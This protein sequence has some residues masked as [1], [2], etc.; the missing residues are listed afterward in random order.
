MAT[1][2]TGAREQIHRLEDQLDPRRARA[3]VIAELNE[4]FA[5]GRVPD[6]VPDGLLRGRALSS[7]ISPF[8]DAAG[9]RLAALYMPWLGK[10]FDAAAGAGINLLAAS[11][12]KPMKMMW[13]SYEPTQVYADRVEAFPFTIRVDNGAVDPDARVLKIDYDSSANPRFII[14][15]VLDE[16][17]EV[18]TSLY[19]GKV[20]YRFGNRW[21]PI[22]WFTL[23]S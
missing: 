23:E 8:F 18:D 20:L 12:L 3:A 9:R 13:P 16:L 14:R 10:R 6:P 21:H 22:G 4:L 17:V 7:T 11:A 19:L 1:T 5:G 2:A 15:R